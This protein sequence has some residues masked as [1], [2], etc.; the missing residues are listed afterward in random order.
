MQALILL[1][2]HDETIRLGSGFLLKVS[3]KGAISFDLAGQVEISLW[4]RNCKSIVEKAAGILTIGSMTVDSSFVRAQL[5]FSASSE[6]RLTLKSDVDFGSS[7][8]MICMQLSQPDTLTRYN[9]QKIERIPHGKHKI[10][11]VRYHKTVNPGRT[12]YLNRKNNEFCKAML[13]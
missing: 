9:V 12:Y 10:R 13:N 7:R 3:V 5:A 4:N 2:D 8:T 1:Q 11:S 6:P